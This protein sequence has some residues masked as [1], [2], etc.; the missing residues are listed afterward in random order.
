MWLTI[1]KTEEKAPKK[2]T[3]DCKAISAEFELF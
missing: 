1:Q 3:V 2:A